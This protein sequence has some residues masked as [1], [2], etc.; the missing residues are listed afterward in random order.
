VATK[1]ACPRDAPVDADVLRIDAAAAY[2]GEVRTA[3]KQLKYEGLAEAAGSLSSLLLAHL[4]QHYDPS[5]VDLVLAN[6]THA[7]RRPR[8][9]ELVLGVAADADRARRWPFDDPLDPTLVKRVE[10]PTRAYGGDRALRRRAAE[11]LYE[12]LDLAYPERVANQRIVVYDDVVTTGAQL[13]AVCR[14][15]REMGAADARGLALAWATRVPW[16]SQVVGRQD[17]S[18][19]V[20][21]GLDPAQ[22]AQALG[23][24]GRGLGV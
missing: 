5:T 1:G 10:T 2:S 3:I 20:D 22:P 16:L 24:R 8:H 6:P 4:D 13:A 12:A 17:P 19:I 11:E 14:F 9:T 7:G 23:I 21:V 18:G 15:L